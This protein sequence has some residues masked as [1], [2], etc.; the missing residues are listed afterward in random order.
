MVVPLA[1]VSI[2]IPTYNRPTYLREALE[3]ALAQT[4][5]D[6]EILVFDDA[7]TDSTPQLVRE[8]LSD[9]R[10]SYVRQPMNVGPNRNWRAGMAAVTGAFFCILADDDR[11][12]PTFVER[13]VRPL[14]EDPDAV[15][16][17][18]DHWV[19]DEAGV[20][21]HTV[22]Q[23]MRHQYGRGRMTE[24]RLGD[25]PRVA[26]VEESIYISAALFRRGVIGPEALPPEAESSI[27]GWLFY[28]CVKSGR[29]A[30]Y[31]SE[32]LIDCRWVAGSV[33]RSRRWWPQVARGS[34]YRYGVMLED[35]RMERF[36]PIIRDR[37]VQGWAVYAQNR[38]L[39]GER[40]EAR[41]AAREALRY[42]LR[43]R[44]ALVL[45][46]GYLG[47]LGTQTARLLQWVA[48]RATPFA[49]RRLS[50]AV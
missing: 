2:I 25:F 47:R 17:F 50:T 18:S 40:E 45:G 34:L 8:Y 35:P 9:P 12:H 27:G 13:L 1:K 49:S 30:Y 21:Q 5:E 6:L 46:M 44:A 24:G 3:S 15:L 16:A 32:R 36:H 48:Q 29:G 7:S 22:T 33:S 19:V 26:L 39:E 23:R 28:Q 43:L 38:L 11:L 37:L 10:L 14:A 20:P 41:R 42:R 31:V 4:Y